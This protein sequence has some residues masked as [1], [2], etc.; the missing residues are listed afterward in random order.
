MSRPACCPS[1]SPGLPRGRFWPRRCPESQPEDEAGR[2]PARQRPRCPARPRPWA[3]ERRPGQRW[4]VR[5]QLSRTSPSPAGDPALRPVWPCWFLKTH[6]GGLRSRHG[7]SQETLA[8]GV[9]GAGGAW[10]QMA[11]PEAGSRGPQHS[12][13]GP[14]LVP[15]LP[16]L[17]FCRRRGLGGAGRGTRI[18]LILI[19]Y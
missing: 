3:E 14:F 5:G 2:L 6:Q 9:W 15:A 8:P 4:Q 11:A 1:R 12:G 18:T 10:G 19:I 7:R 17:T 16:T 13:Q